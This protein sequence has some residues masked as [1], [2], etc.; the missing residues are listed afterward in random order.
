MFSVLASGILNTNLFG[1]EPPGETEY[2]IPLNL[3]RQ[4]AQR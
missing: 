4:T 1:A 3:F 2:R